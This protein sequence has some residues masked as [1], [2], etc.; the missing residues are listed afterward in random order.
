MRL[1]FHLITTLLRFHHTF[2]WTSAL[3]WEPRDGWE[4]GIFGRDL[5]EPYHIETMLPGI[6]VE[7]ARVERTFL[8]SIYKKF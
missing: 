7:P 8:L 2:A 4:I 1:R 5:L 6:D 3:V